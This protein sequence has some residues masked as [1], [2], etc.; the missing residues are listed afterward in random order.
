MSFSNSHRDPTFV[1]IKNKYGT[2][3]EPHQANINDYELAKKAV[4]QESIEYKILSPIIMLPRIP[5][6]IAVCGGFVLFFQ[7]LK[8]NFALLII[9]FVLLLYVLATWAAHTYL[10]TIKN[11]VVL[12]NQKKL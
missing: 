12:R 9:F 4:W 3:K 8:H 7:G 1:K 11:R 5:M 10:P 6:L 2:L